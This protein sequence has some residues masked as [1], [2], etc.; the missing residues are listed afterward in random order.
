MPELQFL[1]TLFFLFKILFFLQYYQ[2]DVYCE[3]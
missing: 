2:N 1:N 3:C